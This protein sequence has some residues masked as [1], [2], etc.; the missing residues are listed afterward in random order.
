[1]SIREIGILDTVTFSQ[2]NEFSMMLVRHG[3]TDW[4]ASRLVQGHHDAARLTTHGREQAQLVADSLRELGFD[5]LFT[6]DLDR[7]TETA[8]IIG[9]AIGLTPG[10]D[11]LL[12]ERS[13]GSFE[14]GPIERL[15]SE[16]TGIDNDVLV[17]PDARPLGGESF[18]DVVA[19]AGLFIEREGSSNRLLVVTHGGTIRALRAYGA[20]AP[21]EGLAW[22]PVG[23]C[24][25]WELDTHDAR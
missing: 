22:Y 2:R 9:A 8:T 5:H 24:S 3:E 17:D 6:S 25:L 14:G 12:R 4:N 1:M 13:F 15:T 11:P 7:A 16:V 20:R 18:R 19:R 23:N 21:L 10:I